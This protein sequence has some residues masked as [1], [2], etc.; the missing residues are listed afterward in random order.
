MEIISF[1]AVI[2]LMLV[3]LIVW[4]KNESNKEKKY[5]ERKEKECPVIKMFDKGY[6]EKL[7]EEKEIEI[8]EGFIESRFRYDFK[9]DGIPFEI[10]PDSNLYD[11]S[12]F[13]NKIIVKSP[14]LTKLIMKKFK[15]A[16]E[17]HNNECL[18]KLGKKYT[19]NNN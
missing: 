17:K 19:T 5:L 16:L 2:V 7:F 10:R 14:T 4:I 8:E 18:K 3:I 13:L 1:I 6:L 12:I 9:I 15:K 11:K